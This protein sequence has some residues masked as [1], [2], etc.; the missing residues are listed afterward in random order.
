MEIVEKGKTA[1]TILDNPVFMEAV[2]KYREYIVKEW[3]NE[4]DPEAQNYR[5]HEQNALDNVLTHLQSFVEN[6]TY[7]GAKK[8]GWR[9]N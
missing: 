7:E 9:N 1:K 4:D 8:K 3:M 2:A 5:W 6:G